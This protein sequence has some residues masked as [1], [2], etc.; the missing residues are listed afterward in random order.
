MNILLA[1]ADT[2]QEVLIR[3]ALNSTKVSYSLQTL[4]SE[5]AVVKYLLKTVEGSRSAPDIMLLDPALFRI[6][7]HPSLSRVHH[8]PAF[9]N[10]L[11]YWYLN[12]TV[13]LAKVTCFFPAERKILKAHDFEKL[14]RNMDEIFSLHLNW[15]CSARHKTFRW[16]WRHNDEIGKTETIPA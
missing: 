1:D 7:H 4:R 14:T 8:H 12:S 10:A 3:A 15:C 2:E 5:S 9:K 16:D 11:V 13:D 6:E